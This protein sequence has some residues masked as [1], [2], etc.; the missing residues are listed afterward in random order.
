MLNEGKVTDRA[1]ELQNDWE[2]RSIEQATTQ[3]RNNV[4]PT[5]PRRHDVPTTSKRRCYAAVC[6]L[7]TSAWFFEPVRLL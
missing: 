3:R 1:N 4:I 5:S 2:T 7:G 6:L